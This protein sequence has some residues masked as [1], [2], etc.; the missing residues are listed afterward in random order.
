MPKIS[1]AIAVTPFLAVT[2]SG[3]IRESVSRP[4]TIGRSI[5][6]NFLLFSASNF[7]KRH[8]APHKIKTG[9]ITIDKVETMD[10]G[11]PAC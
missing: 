11:I 5:S 4:P 2:V 6:L 8:N 1:I 7:F 9:T 3:E 10:P